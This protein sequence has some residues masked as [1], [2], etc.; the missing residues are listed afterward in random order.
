MNG[1]GVEISS[2]NYV[3]EI[4]G[5][6]L[7]LFFVLALTYY[8]TKWIAGYQ[9]VQMQGRNLQVV[10]TLRVAGNKY[11]Q[12]VK[13]GSEYLVV[14]IGKDEMSLL[15]TLTADQLEKLPVDYMEKQLSGEDFR[16]ILEKVKKHLPKK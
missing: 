5:L 10:E 14:A 2:L 6:L 9:K 15:A 3:A 12:I 7:I 13:A 1:L 4:F 11:I 8:V 16:N